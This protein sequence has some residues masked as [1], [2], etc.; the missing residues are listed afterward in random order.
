MK[1]DIIFELVGNESMIFTVTC[2]ALKSAL[3]VYKSQLS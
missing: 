1:Y 2:A 3:K